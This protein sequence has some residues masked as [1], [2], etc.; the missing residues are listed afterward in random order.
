MDREP[1]VA[2]QFYPGSKTELQKKVAMY[3]DGTPG[4]K[5]TLLAMCPHAGY[6]FSGP[7]AGKTLSRASLRNT[8]ILL[9]PNHTGSG[10]ELAVWPD[11]SWSIP[12]A[13]IE[14]HHELAEQTASLP[15][16]EADYTAHLRE[17]SL[18]VILPFLAQIDT[19]ITIVPVSV[20]SRDPETV[21][22]AG[23]DL[24]G[25]IRESGASVSVVVSSDMSHYI[26]ED[27][28]R[29]LDKMALEQ[30]LALSAP[31]LLRTVVE[32]RISMCG[33]L[34]MALGL[35]CACGLGA[36]HA[37]V[38]AYSTSGEV[39]GDKDQVVG[40]AGVLVD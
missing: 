14:V 32:N 24:A 34:P 26:P 27:R 11:G 7:V 37:E 16:F 13:K 21:L 12:G 2:G 5:K 29:R 35:E 28:A 23:R 20:S 36:E 6:M 25:L 17:H 40:Y 22:M 8:I 33:V 10:A 9:G 19:G 4:A 30:I 3:M 39:L 38:I 1:I 18:E 31:G 15:G